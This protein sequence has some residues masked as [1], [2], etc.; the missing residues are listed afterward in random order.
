MSR[1]STGLA[2]RTARPTLIKGVRGWLRNTLG[3]DKAVGFTILARSWAAIASLV[4]V[5][6][7]AR[8][9]TPAEQGYYYTFAS[10]VALQLVFELGFSSVI[11]Q[12]ASH[13]TA[14][15]SISSDHVVTGDPVAHARLASVL[16]KSLR[17]YTVAAVVMCAGLIPAGIYFFADHS[18][19]SQHVAWRIPWIC[20]VIAATLT[21]Q[22]DPVFSF[23]EGCGY[24]PQVA[25][26]R[27]RQAL[28]GSILAWAA[29][30]LHHGLFAPAMMIFGQA[31]A[32]GV[33]LFSRRH[34]LYSLLRRAPGMDNIRWGKEVWPFQWRI[35]VSWICGY[36]VFQLFNP[37]LFA[38]WGPVAAGQLGMSLSV[39]NGLASV[40]VSWISTKAAPFGTMIA[41]RQFAELDSPEF[42]S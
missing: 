23:L 36:F 28:T 19:A 10:L 38:F 13:E 2:L 22:I 29:L 41:R 11:L 39:C 8:F 6:L 35:A 25:N 17:W 21:F 27:F 34:L 9:L 5:G 3:L 7:I 12:M 30:V 33:M 16:Q 31:L 1:G 37:I 40:A 26:T 32:G 18:D 20:D 14:R 42:Q 24:V 15:L 4:T